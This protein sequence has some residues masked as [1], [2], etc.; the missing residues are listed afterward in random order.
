MKLPNKTNEA[1]KSIC[2]Y[3]YHHVADSGKE[4]KNGGRNQRVLQ[5]AQLI[6]H[7]IYI[8]EPLYTC[9]VYTHTFIYTFIYFVYVFTV[10]I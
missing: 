8:Y 9:N 1:Y 10:R 4:Q 2:E 6:T 3:T 5:M 7:Y